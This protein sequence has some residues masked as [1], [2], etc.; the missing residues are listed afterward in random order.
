MMR[1]FTM[2]GGGEAYL[3][4]M[5]NEFGHPEWI[6]FPREGNGWSFHYCRRQWSLYK[7]GFL[8]YEWLGNFDRDIVHLAKEHNIFEQRMADQLLMKGPEQAIVFKRKGLLFAFNWNPNQSLENV[9]VPIPEKKDY[10]LKLSSDDAVYGG[11]GQVE[12]MV[13]PAKEFDGQWFIELY[14]PARTALV[15]EEV[16]EKKRAKKAVKK[17]DTAEKAEKKTTKKTTKNADTAE[18]AEKKTTKKTTKKAD[19]AEKAETKT[20][21]KTTKKAVKAEE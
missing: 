13:Y 21:K 16:P 20:T 17:A 14:M 1:L 18:K 7:N 15:F 2:A 9:L 4:F 6:D 11:F 3:N 12:P 8:K 10:M 19:T 5:G